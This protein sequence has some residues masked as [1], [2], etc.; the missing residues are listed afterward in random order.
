[1]KAAIAI[2]V[3]F[4]V[5]GI[6]GLVWHRQREK[7]RVTQ[8]QAAAL[9]SEVQALKSELATRPAEPSPAPPA[10]PASVQPPARANSTPPADPVASSTAMLKDPETRALMRKQQQQDLA[11]M[12]GK[13]VSKEFARDWNLSP[14]QAAQVKEL[15]R[16]KAA[17][18][19][20]LL[21]AMMFDGLDD[22]AL[23]QR[24]RETKE[25]LDQ[26]E[27]ALRGLLGPDGFAALK[28]QKHRLEDGERVK[29]FR[30]E[31][32]STDEPL[33]QSQV[34]SL[35]EVFALERQNF[36]FRVDYGDI[37]KV[38]FEHI[39]DYFSEANLQMYFEDL[40][41]FNA[42]I[43]ERAALLLSP[44]QTDQLKTAQNNQLERGRITVKMT[45]ELFNKRRAN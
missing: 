38:D 17:A 6:G 30:E 2:L 16:A 35:R 24:G 15:V 12:A 36:S 25:R 44:A 26:S 7:D 43:A 40:Q 13:I 34:E 1:M 9:E 23:A 37:S 41:E 27:A 42:R 19:K 20:D 8:H 3:L 33:T 31:L 22:K 21:T 4:L 45:T 10:L 28:G 11:R 29:R 32:A 14:E 39:R 18:G 5:G